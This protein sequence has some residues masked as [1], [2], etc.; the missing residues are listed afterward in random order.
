[1]ALLEPSCLTGPY[2]QPAGPHQTTFSFLSRD[3]QMRLTK[4]MYDC[5][6]PRNYLFNYATCSNLIWPFLTLQSTRRAV[7]THHGR[8]CC[9]GANAVAGK[10]RP[11]TRDW[12]VQIQKHGHRDPPP[13]P[14]SLS[15]IFLSS[16]LESKLD[17][18]SESSWPL[19]WCLGPLVLCKRTAG[20]SNQSNDISICMPPYPGRRLCDAGACVYNVL[21]QAPVCL[22]LCIAARRINQTAIQGPGPVYVTAPLTGTS[23][24]STHLL[25]YVSVF[26]L[27]HVFPGKQTTTAGLHRG[28]VPARELE[29]TSLLTDNFFFK[30]AAHLRQAK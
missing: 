9:D 19:W 7:E 18:D 24:R 30:E 2:N 23:H 4:H 10:L 6:G 17:S 20:T 12:S 13:P 16:R 22:L 26:C 14:P 5:T 1:M 11:L 3:R 29:G 27:Q 28:M 8:E 25:T 15:F 21:R